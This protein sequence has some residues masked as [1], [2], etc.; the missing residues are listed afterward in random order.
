MYF[1]EYTWIPK[2]FLTPQH[3]GHCCTNVIWGDCCDLG[4]SWINAI[5]C[6]NY[7]MVMLALKCLQ[8][9]VVQQFILTMTSGLFWFVI[10]GPVVVKM[11]FLQYHS[12]ETTGYN[13][14]NVWNPLLPNNELESSGRTDG[15]KDMWAATHDRPVRYTS[16]AL[17]RDA[18]LTRMKITVFWDMA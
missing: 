8:N 14:G 9:I 13:N 7:N 12:Y 17:D 16:L 6:H 2:A 10:R 18:H 1:L 5:L 11:E 4:H 15:R 3:A